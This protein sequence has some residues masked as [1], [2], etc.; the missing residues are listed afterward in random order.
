MNW[1]HKYGV[2]LVT[3]ALLAVGLACAA[4][5]QCGCR[6]LHIH[7]HRHM[8]GKP[9]QSVDINLTD[10]DAPLEDWEKP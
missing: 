3:Y 5:L 2:E 9:T 7:Y 1:W 6:D 8:D 10:P 4:T